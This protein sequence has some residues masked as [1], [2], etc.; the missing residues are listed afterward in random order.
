MKYKPTSLRSIL[1]VLVFFLVS[2]VMCLSTTCFAEEIT[3]LYTGETHAMIYPCSCPKEPDG[4]VAR[5]SALIRKLRYD[6]ANTIVLDSGG[7]FPGGLQDEY[8]QNA[9]LD[10]RRA[11]VNLN[12]MELMGYDAAA[13]GDDEFNYGSDFLEENIAGKKMA[14]LSCNLIYGGK[15][16]NPF[17][18]YIIKEAGGKKIGIIGVTGIFASE[19]SGNIKFM[20]PAIAVKAAVE[21]LK[22]INADIIILL[23]HL[24]ES[25]DL[26][27]INNI[28]GIDIV[29][30]GQSRSREEQFTR[31]GNSLVL[32]P[33]WQGRKLGKLSMLL[34]NGKIAGYQTEELR[35]S[36]G[37]PEDPDLY[38]TLPKCFSDNNCKREGYIGACS[39]PGT[40]RSECV[41]SKAAE[42]PLLVVTSKLCNVC[43]TQGPVGELKKIFPGLAV[44]Y[45][46][47]PEEKAAGLIKDLGISALPAFLLGKEAAQDRSF[48]R[49]RESV[50]PRGEFYMLRPEVT[51]IGYFLGRKEIKGKLDLFLSLFQKDTPL[52]LERIKGFQPQAHFLAFEN[53]DGNFETKGGALETEE[54]LRSVCVEK[55]YPAKFWDYISCRAKSI[56]TS[57]WQD[58][59]DNAD[60]D[61]ITACARGEEGKRLLRENISLNRQLKISVGPAYLFDNQKVFASRGVPTNEELKRIL[62]R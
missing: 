6:N 51:G 62:K 50:E 40:M 9:D 31:I 47:Y 32:R 4:G 35:L 45:I 52:L 60:T 33:V 24:G 18:P 23:S 39:E 30:V 55:Y 28:P 25:E 57:W 14:L 29:I 38:L 46:Y 13:I 53:P 56:N 27:L 34:E 16:K 58:C 8:S 10:M 36:D 15:K 49:L 20:E 41:Y 44:S 19:K 42:V 5:R 48:E 2:C 37:I 43:N 1:L 12:A 11:A 61:K 17:K 21:E 26:K 7:F 22:K 59:L 3:I 54:C